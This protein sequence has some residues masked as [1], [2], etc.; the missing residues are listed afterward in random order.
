MRA[1]MK[2]TMIRVL[3]KMGQIR[4]L[5]ISWNRDPQVAK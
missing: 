5:Q 3:E 2:M 4:F 1:I